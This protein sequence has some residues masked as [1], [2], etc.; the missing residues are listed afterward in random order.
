M[1]ESI[2]SHCLFFHLLRDSGLGRRV[3]KSILTVILN[4]SSLF[5]FPPSSSPHL[6]FPVF[7]FLYFLPSSLPTPFFPHPPFFHPASVLLSFPF[8][9]SS[10]LLSFLICQDVLSPPFLKK[11]NKTK[12]RHNRKQTSSK[13]HFL[14]G[15]NRDLGWDLSGLTELKS[16]L[17]DILYNGV[18][19]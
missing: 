11:Q 6:T 4:V 13:L 5:C 3:A 7:P 17:E 10:F 16:R 15:V 8:F 2:S 19:L 1:F 9:L 14:F 12:N 18:I